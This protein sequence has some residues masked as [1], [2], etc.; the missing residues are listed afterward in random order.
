MYEIAVA[1]LMKTLLLLLLA[2]S[3]L[4]CC[5][6][7]KSE[8]TQETIPV[9][10]IDSVRKEKIDY[11][12]LI[13]D[14]LKMKRLEPVVVVKNNDERHDFKLLEHTISWSYE[15]NKGI[16]MII[17]GRHITTRGKVTLN[18]VW[19][20]SV[21]S[22]D[23]P[24]YIDQIKI[25]EFYEDQKI[26]NTIICFDMSFRPCNGIGCGV[27]YQLLYDMKT[28]QESYFGNY[29]GWFGFDLYDFNRDQKVDYLGKTFYG[30]NSDT[31]T[32]E[33]NEY[34]LY[35]QSKDGK[36]RVFK[37]WQGKKYFFEHTYSD[38]IDTIPN[39]FKENW[40]QKIIER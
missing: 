16:Y 6:N 13:D 25:Y 9:E 14:Y 27:S 33:K 23:F 21:D 2:I 29:R 18:P 40:I 12:A 39:T 28:G 3:F 22:L 4:G 17:D 1:R 19:G 36:F 26:D 10:K 38:E 15:E 7:K 30:R 20:E 35:S 11:H 24:N 37:N 31:T 8:T 5:D 34:I 32:I